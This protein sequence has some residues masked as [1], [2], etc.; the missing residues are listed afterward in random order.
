[1]DNAYVTKGDAQ[2]QTKNYD[3]AIEFYTKAIN[4]NTGNPYPSNKIREISEMLA[5]NKL[6]DLT[7]DVVTI[8][9]SETKRFDFE[10]VDA[11]T[12]R[13]NY[14]II[15]AKSLSERQFIMY[16]TYGSKLGKNGGFT[17]TVPKNQDVNDFIIR[18]GSQYKWFSEDN[19]WIEILPENGSIEITS[20]E[21]TKGN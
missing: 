3:K 21:I 16:I 6:V 7:T 12:R 8:S 4:L 19:T 5:A 9:A 10:P 13:S 1:M 17:V 20:M 14:L 11:S 18:I 2:F 15:K